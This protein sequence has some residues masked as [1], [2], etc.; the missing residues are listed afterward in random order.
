MNYKFA[1]SR[2][3]TNTGEHTYGMLIAELNKIC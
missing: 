3:K 1:G 2:D